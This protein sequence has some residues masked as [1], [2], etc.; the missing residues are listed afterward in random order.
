MSVAGIWGDG[1]FGEQERTWAVG[2][3]CLHLTDRGPAGNMA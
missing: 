3:G 2:G 1:A